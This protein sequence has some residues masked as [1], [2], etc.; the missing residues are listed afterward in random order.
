MT[1]KAA[2]SK[3]SW[4]TKAL[5]FEGDDLRKFRAIIGLHARVLTT[6]DVLMRLL[7]I[8]TMLAELADAEL[9]GYSRQERPTNG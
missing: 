3:P 5:T 1:T 2:H 9:H 7:G 8:K 4:R 6:E